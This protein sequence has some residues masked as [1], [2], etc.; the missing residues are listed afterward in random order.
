M[1][2]VVIAVGGEGPREAITSA[3]SY[4]LRS[5][6]ADGTA[7]CRAAG[8]SMAPV[9]GDGSLL[10]LVKINH[11]GDLKIGDVVY[12]RTR[13][14]FN[15][16]MFGGLVTLGVGGQAQ[17]WA[18]IC[19]GD[20]SFDQLVSPDDILAKVDQVIHNTLTDGPIIKEQ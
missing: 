5:L 4:I 16:H 13:A 7:Y 18:V 9:Y 15:R 19:Y 8:N 11:V 3:D 20:G 2:D 17:R 12:F 6:I 1:T 14:G 10:Q